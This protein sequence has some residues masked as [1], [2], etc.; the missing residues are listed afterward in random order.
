MPKT[1]I[2]PRTDSTEQPPQPTK[3]RRWIPALPWARVALAAAPVALAV[4]YLT[5]VAPTEVPTL[6]TLDTPFPAVTQR[7]A[8]VSLW[9]AARPWSTAFIG[10]G[11]LVLGA[12]LPIDRDRYYT[13]LAIV[14]GLLL[15]FTYYSI[16]AP[17]ERLLEGVRQT[18]PEERMLPDPLSGN[19]KD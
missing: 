17:I 12:I 6:N 8:E 19:T 2:Q 16:S 7:L 5:Q 9:C 10:L 3:R 13:R 11:L 14:V 1:E 4:Y 18:L 15:G